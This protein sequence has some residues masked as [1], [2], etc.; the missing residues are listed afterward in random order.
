MRH[1]HAFVSAGLIAIVI[2]Q[3]VLVAGPGFGTLRK[4]KLTL[5]VRQPA[6]LRLSNASFAVKAKV[7]NNQYAQVLGSLESTLETELVSNEKTLTKK[8]ENEA[9]WIFDLTVTGFSVPP[10]KKRTETAGT[11]T[12]VYER[13]TGSL[14]VAYQVFDKSGTVHSADNVVADYDEEFQANGARSGRGLLS[15][16]PFGG[17][18][19]KP[20]KAVSSPEDV[21][22]ALIA[23]V[24]GQIAAKLGNTVQAVEVQLAGGDEHLDRAATFLEQKLWSR[25]AEEL[26]RTPPYIKPDDESYRQYMLGLTYEAMSY[27]GNVY[28]EQRANLFKA[29]EA[30]DKANEM[31]V[32]QKYFVEVIA[33]TKESVARYRTLDAMQKEDQSKASKT[34][35]RTNGTPSAAATAAAA[36]TDKKKMVTLN[37][38]IELRAAGV[39]DA[40]IIELIQTSPVEFVLDK[41]SVLAISKAKLPV[42]LQNELRK[43]A[44]LPLLPAAPAR[45]NAPATPAPVKP[46]TDRAEAK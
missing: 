4:R 5:Q 1:P 8:P 24:V 46:G 12:L 15:G 6:A 20:E 9:Q 10:S 13:W 23:K 7:A 36:T 21:K 32:G 37:D 19:G 16:L 30:Y 40:Q 33:R 35:A 31:N 44:G 26:E 22:Q 29:Q 11:T 3:A 25:A 18:P 43:K 27:D 14:N 38:V 41:D 34:V 2:S 28:A 42:N 39:P 17:K 45:S